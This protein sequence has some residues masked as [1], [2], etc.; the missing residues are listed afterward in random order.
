MIIDHQHHYVPAEFIKAPAGDA[1]TAEYTGGNPSYTFNPLI[2]N[3]DAH[4]AMMDE[5]GVDASV[6]TASAGMDNPDLDQCRRINDGMKEAEEKYPGRYIGMAHL[7]IRGEGALD[8]LARCRDEL[9]FTGAVTTSE[10]QGLG[11]DAPELDDYYKAVSDL[12]MYLFVHPL[13]TSL[14]YTQLDNDYDLQRSVGR[15]FSLATATVRLINGGVLDRFPDLLVQISHLAGG[16]SAI[17]G[18]VRRHQEKE[19]LGIADHPRHG[20][21]PEKDFMHYMR[22]RLIFDTS[23]VTLEINA[24]KSALLEIPAGRIVFATDYPQEPKRAEQISTYIQQV[25]ALG[26]DGETILKSDDGRL[27]PAGHV[28]KLAASLA[29]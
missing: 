27:M 16:L 15:E 4:L 11:L 20:K 3:L 9:G 1:P 28:A 7:P 10:P 6:L 23:G 5:A 25:R 18:R 19:D 2:S 26:P 8:E 17:L 24:L 14:S 12:G 22:E 21:L 29:G 13:L